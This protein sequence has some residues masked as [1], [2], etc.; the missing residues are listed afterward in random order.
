MQTASGRQNYVEMSKKIPA[1][2]NQ[3]G[4]DDLK[5]KNRLERQR[6]LID[7]QKII[8]NVVGT[9]GSL[10]VITGEEITH[11]QHVGKVIGNFVCS[12]QIRFPAVFPVQDRPGF[13]RTSIGDGCH[14]V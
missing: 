11:A 5:S 10:I 8:I 1:G 2:E 12:R 13:I 7:N 4:F 14:N 3:R 9:I 6:Q